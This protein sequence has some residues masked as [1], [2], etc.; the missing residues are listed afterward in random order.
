MT[1]ILK[2]ATDVINYFLHQDILC[3]YDG[4]IGLSVCDIQHLT[5]C[6]ILVLCLNYMDT[7]LGAVLY[8]WIKEFL[9]NQIQMVVVNGVEY[10]WRGATSGIPQG[11]ILGPVLFLIS[12]NDLPEVVEVCVKLVADDTKL[13]KR[14]IRQQYTQPVYRSLPQHGLKTGI[15]SLMIQRTS[16]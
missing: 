9:S 1:F 12:I 16:K 2:V 7:E 5:G 11:S 14:I 13:Y 3:L 6:R 15:W 4:E 8:N 10:D